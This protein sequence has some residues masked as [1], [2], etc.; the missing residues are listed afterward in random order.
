MTARQSKTHSG[1]QPATVLKPYLY[2]L[3]LRLS[4]K[5]LGFSPVSKAALVQPS[6]N[7]PLLRALTFYQKSVSPWIPKTIAR[8]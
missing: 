7:R 3:M 6:T 2:H 5:K 1:I 4:T 8:K